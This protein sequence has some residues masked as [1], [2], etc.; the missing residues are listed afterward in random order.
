MR[1]EITQLQATSALLDGQL[2][3]KQ[4]IIVSLQETYAQTKATQDKVLEERAIKLQKDLVEAREEWNQEYTQIGADLAK[5]SADQLT[6]IEKNKAILA[7][8]K[9]KQLVYIKEQMHKEEMLA[10]QD[11]YRPAITEED[12]EDIHL[13]RDVQSRLRKK[14]AIDKIIWSVYYKP[15]YDVLC[16]HIFNTK[17]KVCGIYKITSLDSGM[18]YIGQSVDI[19]SRFADHL[20]SGLDCGPTTNKLYQAMKKYQPCNFLFEI[21]EEVPRNQLN[22]REKYYIDFYCTQEV[23]MN[24][25]MG[26]S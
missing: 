9:A 25:T 14:D 16:S 2:A 26:G 23:G 22:E 21:L 6:A 20:K 3:N 11:Y 13:L 10:Q 5:F 19:K 4:D 24:T 1:A 15:A 8:L 18:A 12:A 17:D 7:D